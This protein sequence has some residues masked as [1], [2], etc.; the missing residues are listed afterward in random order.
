MNVWFF[1]FSFS[2]IF[3]SPV[4]KL[5]NVFGFFLFVNFIYFC[6]NLT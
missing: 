2:L 4:V 1:P 5:D 6:F 3:V